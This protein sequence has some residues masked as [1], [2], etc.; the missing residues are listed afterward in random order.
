MAWDKTQPA[1]TTKIRISD[2]YIRENWA[3]LEAALGSDLNM[4][5]SSQ[6]VWLYANS[7]NASMSASWSIVAAV[8]DTLLA[9]KGGTTYTTGGTSA[10]TWQQPNHTLTLAEIPPHYHRLP[11]T[12]RDNQAANPNWFFSRSQK[13]PIE[14]RNTDDGSADGLGGGP[15]NHG[16][17]YRPMARVGLLIQKS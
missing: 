17:T 1:G 10:G 14:Y 6:I 12:S 3:A 2:N 15:H 16:N 11:N 9:V 4:G 5:L 7:L 13:N 8:G